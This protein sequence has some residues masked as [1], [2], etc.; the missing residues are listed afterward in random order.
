MSERGGLESFVCVRQLRQVIQ[1]RQ[2]HTGEPYCKI[3]KDVL[4]IPFENTQTGE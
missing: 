1:A 3:E 4:T 2:L